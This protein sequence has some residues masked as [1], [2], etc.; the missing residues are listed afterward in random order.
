[1]IE[2]MYNLIS[3][4]IVGVAVVSQ[5]SCNS[6]YNGK[7]AELI[8]NEKENFRQEC[9][10]K[11]DYTIHNGSLDD[12]IENRDWILENGGCFLNLEKWICRRDSFNPYIE[13][14]YQTQ[15]K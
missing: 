5:L 15:F 12:I 10:G 6:G 1:M 3:K 9:I 2:R 11:S 4:I 8:A 13:G 14:K 7:C